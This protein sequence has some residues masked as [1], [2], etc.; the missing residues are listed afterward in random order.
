MYRESTGVG[1]FRKKLVGEQIPFRAWSTL[2]SSP[3]KPSQ[4]THRPL[5]R[6]ELDSGRDS[7][8]E[9]E[10]SGRPRSGRRPL[11]PD[12]HPRRSHALRTRGLQPARPGPPGILS[13]SSPS[14][15]A[16]ASARNTSTPG[17]SCPQ[18]GAGD[19]P[20]AARTA[21]ERECGAP[22]GPDHGPARPAALPLLVRGTHARASVERLLGRAARLVAPDLQL[23]TDPRPR[24][25][26][27]GLHSR[28][29]SART[30]RRPDRR[31]PDADPAHRA[32]RSRPGVT[33]NWET[34][35]STSSWPG[36]TGN[37]GTTTCSPVRPSGPLAS[38]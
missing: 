7:A 35:G 36:N 10:R 18:G 32:R 37:S 15:H 5:C 31:R 14:K 9:Q 13:H 8:L 4:L 22:R 19:E 26:A 38:S 2:S 23:Q 6:V 20:P 12:S 30:R 3:P 24:L 29:R 27:H 1:Y 34:R 33:R 28:R 16:G 17:A 11:I 21:R 25:S